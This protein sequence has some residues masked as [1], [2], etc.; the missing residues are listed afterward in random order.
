MVP[1]PQAMLLKWWATPAANLTYDPLNATGATAYPITAPTYIL[2]YTKYSDAAVGN[3]LKAFIKYVLTTGQK[4]APK[5]DFAPLP[6]SLASQAVAQLD[7]I[8]VG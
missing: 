8:T 5:V 3:A 6:S 7:K 2:A 4:T 1:M